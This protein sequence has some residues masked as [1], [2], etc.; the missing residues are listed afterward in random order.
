MLDVLLEE[1]ILKIHILDRAASNVM[2]GEYANQF[3]V[4][5]DRHMGD[6]QLGHQAAQVIDAVFRMRYRRVD[7]H[8]IT[9]SRLHQCATL[10]IE[11]LQH[12]LERDEP[13]HFITVRD[14]H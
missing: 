8:D 9:A 2:V 14:D 1:A 3:S 11:T 4:V 5:H 10:G 7:F 12:F 6:V 13:Q